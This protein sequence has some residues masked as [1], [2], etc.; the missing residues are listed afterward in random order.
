MGHP[1][2]IN[3][4]FFVVKSYLPKAALVLF[5]VALFSGKVFA[6]EATVMIDDAQKYQKVT[7]FGGFVNSPQFRSEE[8]RVGKS[9]DLCVRCGIKKKVKSMC[10]RRAH[11]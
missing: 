2:L 10:E 1:L 11:R 5:L 8:R 7:G 9:V 4:N 3:Q 6:Q